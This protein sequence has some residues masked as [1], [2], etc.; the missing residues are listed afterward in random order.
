MS[1][2]SSFRVDCSAG[3]VGVMK[4]ILTF[5][6]TCFA[7]MFAMP[8]FATDRETFT[9]SDFMVFARAYDSVMGKG[10]SKREEAARAFFFIGYVK[11][12]VESLEAFGKMAK[13]NGDTC[14]ICVALP[15]DYYDLMGNEAV[16]EYLHD[17]PGEDATPAWTVV[18]R[19]LSEAFPVPGFEEDPGK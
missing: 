13:L 3:K 8:C 15:A 17:H 14:T 12:V 5:V 9:L 6:L 18:A 11:G 1:S 10:Y 4:R 16:L 7:L 2:L 19:A